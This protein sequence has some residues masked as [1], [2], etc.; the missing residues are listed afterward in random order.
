MLDRRRG[1]RLGGDPRRDVVQFS[2]LFLGQA[3][4]QGESL[5][6]VEVDAFHHNAFGLADDVAVGQ[7]G[8]QVLFVLGGGDRRPRPG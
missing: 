8:V 5:V 6:G 1:G 4:E 2:V 3:A 7:C